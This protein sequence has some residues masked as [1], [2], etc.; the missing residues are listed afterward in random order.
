MNAF[1]IRPNGC[2]QTAIEERLTEQ[3]RA[4]K[5]AFDSTTV[6]FKRIVED[7]LRVHNAA[8]VKYR[9]AL[10]NFNNFILSGQVPELPEPHPRKI[11]PEEGRGQ[12]AQD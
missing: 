10:E 12:S 6:Q 4:A 3:L 9:Q 7:S 1:S 11:P 8:Y 2:D 5:A